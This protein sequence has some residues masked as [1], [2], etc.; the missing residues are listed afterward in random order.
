MKRLWEPLRDCCP[1]LT[2]SPRGAAVGKRPERRLRYCL[3]AAVRRPVA[4]TA[5][6]F[7]LAGD[8]LTAVMGMEAA[9]VWERL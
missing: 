7:P 4:G 9:S 5:P 3:C 1:Y 6:G 8:V 2:L